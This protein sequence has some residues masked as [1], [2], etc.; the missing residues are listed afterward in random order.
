MKD[1]ILLSLW[2]R[3]RKNGK[4][5]PPSLINHP[6]GRNILLSMNAKGDTAFRITHY[7]TQLTAKLGDHIFVRVFANKPVKKYEWYYSNAGYTNF[8]LTGSFTD[9]YY[10][11]EMS[12]ERDGRKIYCILTDED[13]NKIQTETFTFVMIE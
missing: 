5:A 8:T 6:A 1:P 11:T 7:Q 13:G 4:K 3:L 10:T 9:Y 2:A 12:K